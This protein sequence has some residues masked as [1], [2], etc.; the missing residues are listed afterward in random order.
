MRQP[1][2]VIVTDS[3][4]TRR[5]LAAVPTLRWSDRRTD[6]GV[7]Y[8]SAD[9]HGLS[10]VALHFGR[11][12]DRLRAL[13]GHFAPQEVALLAVTPAAL[14]AARPGDVVLAEARGEAEGGHGS[15]DCDPRG[16]EPMFLLHEARALFRDDWIGRRP[17]SARRLAD[18]L[19]LELYEQEASDEE[20]FYRPG[21]FIGLP[22]TGD[23]RVALEVLR[24]DRLLGESLRL[25]TQG[26]TRASEL[27]VGG[28]P[29]DPPLE[30]TPK[31][32]EEVAKVLATAPSRL[33]ISDLAGLR[34][35]SL[36]IGCFDAPDD[37]RP[38]RF[39]DF[40]ADAATRI[41]LTDLLERVMPRAPRTA[42]HIS[43]PDADHPLDPTALFATL[44][45]EQFTAFESLDLDLCPGLNVLIGANGTGKSHILKALYA[46]ARLRSPDRLPTMLAA[47]FRPAD[48]DPNR[49][50]RS[51]EAP[52][53]VEIGWSTAEQARWTLE[54]GGRPNVTEFDM[55][56]SHLTG[57]SACFVPARECL[58][59]AEGLLAGW[60]DHYRLAFDDTYRDLVER[61][62]QDRTIDLPTPLA[63]A[64]NRLEDRLEGDEVVFEHG[65]FYV[66]SPGRRLEAHLLAEGMRKL[67]SVVRLIGNGHLGT[68]G[69]LLW[70]EPASN[71]NPR[72]TTVVARFLCDLAT[73]GVQIVVASHDDL[74]T[75]E[76]DLRARHADLKHPG[77]T[78]RFTC[79]YRPS[80][81]PRAGVVAEQSARLAELG[82]NPIL[83]E[84][85][86]HRE[87]EIGWLV[88][89]DGR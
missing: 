19:L 4:A 79:L 64:L 33:A 5:A 11:V 42:E 47:C 37:G 41:L 55:D 29:E 78:A 40:S 35:L 18:D 22:P 62:L 43:A 26:Q 48:G 73:A 57:A 17:P 46:V 58:S 86:A 7:R 8:E 20:G 32:I 88:E 89:E 44:K 28:V 80:G 25:T 16:V 74:L 38:S 59:L 2:V 12:G 53:R 34:P 60:R 27:L 49:L 31:S 84:F 30:L 1:D 52:A 15:D 75:R 66:G 36:A 51:A 71:L 72:L 21:A 23:T 56:V 83:K 13:I 67:W 77:L 24:R 45:L 68:P 3:V 54:S 39:A 14:L 76:L 81:D 10:L 85:V 63:T 50:W 9:W 69:V 82:H 70:D 61:L 65:R 6:D 87:R